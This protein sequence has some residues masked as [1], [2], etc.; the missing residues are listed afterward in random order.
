MDGWGWDVTSEC[1]WERGDLDLGVAKT[2]YTYI[3]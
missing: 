1:I 2:V 3:Y